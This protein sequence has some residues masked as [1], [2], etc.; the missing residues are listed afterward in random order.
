MKITLINGTKKEIIHHPFSSS[1]CVI[2]AKLDEE[3]NKTS[4]LSLEIYDMNLKIEEFKTLI[5]VEEIM[6][7]KVVFRGRV[8]GLSESMESDGIFTRMLKAEDFLSYL[9]DVSTRPMYY[10]SLTYAQCLNN[11]LW[12]FNDKKR[13][14]IGYQVG[15]VEFEGSM[16]HETKYESCLSA[17]NTLISTL[18]AE[19]DYRYDEK[20][21]VVYID[22]LERRG[23]DKGY[24]VKLSENMISIGK[25]SD[26][27]IITRAIPIGKSENDGILTI[28]SVNGGK[29]YIEDEE[30]IKKYG[31][32][33]GTIE[34]S[35][36]QDAQTLI[37]WGKSKLKEISTP[38]IA[39]TLDLLDMS[40]FSNSNIPSLE[41]GDGINVSNNVLNIN[42]TIR[43]L[44]KTTNLFERHNP[45]ITLASRK[46]RLSDRLIDIQNKTSQTNK[47]FISS[48]EI[49]LNDNI[50]TENPMLETIEIA[51][52][53]T[54]C[55]IQIKI[56]RYRYTTENGI[57]IKEY[58]QNV[59]VII[60]NKRAKYIENIQNDYIETININNYVKQGENNISITC[61]GFAKID[62]ILYTKLYN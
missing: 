52:P 48:S 47:T 13:D 54:H 37:T 56:S 53:I 2:S 42:Q 4:I 44:K 26:L 39:I 15:K 5:E 14:V 34:N 38:K 20:A 57:Q 7:Q 3:I 35:D 10:E 36:I 21:N 61:E 11:I 59:S 50:D 32:I 12:Q 25:E 17:L 8:I 58:P 51:K 49:R 31:I 46:R 23:A 28:S 6:T 55:S 43:C 29:D 27:S 1:S 24:T 9:N 22:L 30:A 19:I 41:L 60:N 33:E 45:S 62:C 16:T 18:N 40:L